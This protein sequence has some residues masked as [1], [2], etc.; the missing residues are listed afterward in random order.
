VFAELNGAAAGVRAPSR[1]RPKPQG[2]DAERKA[3]QVMG[4]VRTQRSN[5]Q[6]E[7]QGAGEAAPPDANGG[8]RSTE[9]R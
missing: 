3:L 5:R 9:D 2:D 8:D 6:G 1:P 7:I 4:S